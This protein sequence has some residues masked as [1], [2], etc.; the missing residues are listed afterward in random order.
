MTGASLYRVMQI[1]WAVDPFESTGNDEPSALRDRAV[2]FLRAWG[3]RA[4][5][6]IEA[7]Y[8]LSPVE[9][10][11]S[12]DIE[13]PQKTLM[14]EQYRQSAELNLDKLISDVAVPQIVDRQVLIEPS[15]SIRT[16][17]E[18]LSDYA[19]QKSA[20]MIV[21]TSHGRKGFQRLLLGSFA[22][23]LL[24]HSDVPVLVIGGHSSEHALDLQR[25]VFAT[26]LG[27][28]SK[29]LFEKTVFQAQQLHSELFLFHALP[30]PVEPVLQSGMY[31]LGGGWVP[32]HQFF[33]EDAEFRRTRLKEWAEWA[34]SKGVRCEW[35]LEETPGSI[36]EAVCHFAEVNKASL[37]SMAAQSGPVA[38]AL[39]G[40]I[41]RQ[42]VRQSQVPVLI[43]RS[44]EGAEMEEKSA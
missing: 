37:I 15:S 25:I 16:S 13:V 14:L 26:D 3:K 6:A 29:E 9:L 19:K 33:A 11:V 34:T 42:V 30:N 39:I 2:D 1:I 21:V 41:V 7:V 8:L 12:L 27:P 20:D 28:H 5:V 23:T 24:L 36:S 18:R 17:V 43:L 32:M 31:L 22:E 10:N 44:L 38:T 40:S 4:D 35:A